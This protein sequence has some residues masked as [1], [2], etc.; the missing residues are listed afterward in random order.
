[1][2]TAGFF[3]LISAALHVLAVALEGFAPEVMILLAPAALYVLLYAGLARAMM[4]AVEAG[5]LAHE[6]DPIEARDMAEASTPVIGK[7]F[8][9]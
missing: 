6:A 1:M 4:G 7:A 8:L 9:S 5:Q 2:K 3:L